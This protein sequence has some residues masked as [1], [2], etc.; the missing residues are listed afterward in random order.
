MKQETLAKDKEVKYSYGSY[1]KVKGD[2]QW[3][4][5]TEGCPHNCPWCYEPQKIKIFNIPKIKKNKVGIIDM[6]LLCKPQAVEIIKKLGKI[7]VNNK[8]VYY[9]FICGIDYRFLT[10]ELAKAIKESKFKNIR[11]AWDNEYNKKNMFGIKDTIDK[12]LKVGYTTKDI[13]VFMIC[14]HERISYEECCKKLDLCKIWNVKVAD[15][16]YDNQINIF[17]KFIPIAWT[18][19]QARDFR[20]RVRKHNQLVNFSI[21]P[22]LK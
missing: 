14:N 16:Y 12:L 10:L 17:D 18:T 6:N 9:E 1:S 20:R 19:E 21:D 2:T 13:T 4:R 7:R 3:I 8:V 22:E 15:C 11:I 5:I